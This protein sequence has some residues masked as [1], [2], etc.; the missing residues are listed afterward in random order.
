MEKN[1]LVLVTGIRLILPKIMTLQK[2]KQKQKMEDVTWK[3]SPL[4]L[5]RIAVWSLQLNRVI[6]AA[7]ATVNCIRAIVLIINFLIHFSKNKLK[8]KYCNE[9]LLPLLLSRK[10][11]HLLVWTAICNASVTHSVQFLTP[12]KPST[13]CQ[14]SCMLYTGHVLKQRVKTK[15]TSTSSWNKVSCLRKVVIHTGFIPTVFGKTR[16]E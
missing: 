11:F 4:Y 10:F 7:T 2:K 9:Y 1:V 8:H 15:E 5:Q 14:H 3:D 13:L 6:E 12:T 16:N